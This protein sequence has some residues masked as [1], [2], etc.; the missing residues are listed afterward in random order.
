MF[1]LVQKFADIKRPQ[2]RYIYIEKSDSESILA[3]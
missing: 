1:R 3:Q 2:S